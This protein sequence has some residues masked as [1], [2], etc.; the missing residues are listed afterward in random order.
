MTNR[1]GRLKIAL[2]THSTNPRG[3]VVHALE[4]ANAL[5]ELG[6]DPVVHAPDV[7]GAGFFRATRC[8]T[9]LVPAQAVSGALED[10][11]RQRIAEYTDYFRP[12]ARRCFDIYHAQDGISGNALANLVE[13]GSIA[14]FIRTVHHIDPFT[15]PDLVAWQ[16][17]AICRAAEVLCVSRMWRDTL[18]LDHAV[19]AT[20]VANGVDVEHYT[21][22]SDAS[23]Q[24]LR[25]RLGIGVG[26]VFLTLGGIEQRKNTVATLEAF[27][28]IR[29]QLT[30]AQLVIAGGASLLDHGTYQRRFEAALAHSALTS[31]PGQA[32]ICTGPLPDAEMPALYR[33]AD[34]LVC[35]SLREGFGLVV[36]EAMASG[37]PVIVSDSEPFTE[38]LGAGDCLWVDPTSS[39][40]IAGGMLAALEPARREGLVAAG[41]LVSKA[42]SW[43]VSAEAHLEIYQKF[44][45]RIPVANG[46][47]CDQRTAERADA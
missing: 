2:L 32:V 16:Q 35:A 25:T 47:R 43:R 18:R 7:T 9:A 28:C 13:Q 38:Y 24:L 20:Q 27:T 17:R 5:A 33:I 3:G 37:I 44:V 4:L 40:S 19:A 41:R 34:A 8:A 21:P 22:R 12:S 1:P 46:H 26:P 39:A 36:L 6:H 29:A 10:L 31:G 11:V 15:H 14:G 30:S 45:A 23:D 42:F